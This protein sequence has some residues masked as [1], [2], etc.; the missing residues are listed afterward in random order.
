M[1]VFYQDIEDEKDAL[2]KV[3]YRLRLSSDAGFN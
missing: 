3:H 2:G 1:R